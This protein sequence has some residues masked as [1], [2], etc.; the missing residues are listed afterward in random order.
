MTIKTEHLPSFTHLTFTN[1]FLQVLKLGSIAHTNSSELI[2]RILWYKDVHTFFDILCWKMCSLMHS[3]L[4]KYDRSETANLSVQTFSVWQFLLLVSWHTPT[5]SPEVL[6]TSLM[7]LSVPYWKE[8]Q[9]DQAEGPQVERLMFWDHL[10]S[11]IWNTLCPFPCLVCLSAE[12][13]LSTCHVVSSRLL[14]P[15]IPLGKTLHRSLLELVTT[16]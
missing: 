13:S 11:H 2:Q 5:W 16:A 3:V 8:D 7:I 15:S 9:C 6:C 14:S 10:H 12:G 4:I 1:L